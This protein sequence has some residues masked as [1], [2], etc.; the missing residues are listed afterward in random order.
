MLQKICRWI[1]FDVMK[2]EA[3]VTEQMPPKYVI[4]LAPHTS[5]WDFVIGNLYSRAVGFQCHFMIKKEWF[6]WPLGY[7]MRAL[8]GIPVTRSRSHSLT[9]Q[10]AQAAMERDEFH[11]C[12]T[13]EGTRRRNE[14]WKRG[15]YYIALK[16]GIPVI[17]YGLDYER[18]RIECTL[19][20][21]P[22]GDYEREVLVVKRYFAQF[23]GKHPEKFA[24][25]LP[26]INKE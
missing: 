12:I 20:L 26:D 15:F 19:T 21:H 24:T 22:T 4:A 10:L 2:Y 9:D 8:G 3:V 7:V 13:P 18:K 23:R 17:C 25:G 5:N 1:L 14:E 6:F 16:A 11:L